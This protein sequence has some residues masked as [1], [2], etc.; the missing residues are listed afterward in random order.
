MKIETSFSIKHPERVCAFRTFLYSKLI[1]LGVRTVG[2]LEEGSHHETG[3]SDGGINN[4]S[5]GSGGGGGGGGS[6]TV[7][8]ATTPPPAAVIGAAALGSGSIT[9]S[10]EKAEHP[11]R[12]Y[13]TRNDEGLFTVAIAFP[14]NDKSVA[15]ASAVVFAAERCVGDIEG[16][17]ETI[18]KIKEDVAHRHDIDRPKG[19]FVTHRPQKGSPVRAV[20][21]EL[22]DAIGWDQHKCE[23]TADDH[24]QVWEGIL[25]T[26]LATPVP[27]SSA[28]RYH[29]SQVA[30]VL[31]ENK[32]RDESVY[33]MFVAAKLEGS[34]LGLRSN[35]DSS[36]WFN[37][38]SKWGN[39][40]GSG[41]GPKFPLNEGPHRWFDNHHYYFS[42]KMF[43]VPEESAWQLMLAPR[44]MEKGG[45]AQ[46]AFNSAPDIPDSIT[47][48]P[49]VKEHK[50]R[51]IQ[52]LAVR[53]QLA[54]A[55]ARGTFSPALLNKEWVSDSSECW[56]L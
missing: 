54:Y 13:C 6:S 15:A 39:E 52:A 45:V 21:G 25:V 55:M 33:I 20:A 3:E 28:Q 27:E 53:K 34:E 12:D 47:V 11:R 38:A 49:I 2:L 7:L 42:W 44:T 32:H 18:A 10:G 56:D 9:A 24:V 4:I 19:H 23:A 1:E 37:C 30:H 36:T 51:W 50:D 5:T 40:L 14:D 17:E 16:G 29:T 8:G 26:K 35:S 48:H 22:P 43:E 46:V 41:N 31:F